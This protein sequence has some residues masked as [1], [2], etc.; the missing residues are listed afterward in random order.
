MDGASGLGKNNQIVEGYTS[1][2]WYVQFMEQGLKK[3]FPRK[4]RSL[5]KR[6]GKSNNRKSEKRSRRF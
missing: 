6:S 4:T 3:E 5:N 1:A 2:E